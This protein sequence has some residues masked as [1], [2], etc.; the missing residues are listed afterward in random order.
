MRG[1]FASGCVA[2]K[3]KGSFKRESTVSRPGEDARLSIVR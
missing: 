2:F 3:F 1:K